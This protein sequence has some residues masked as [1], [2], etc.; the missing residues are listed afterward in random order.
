MYGHV[1]S[2][3]VLG[4]A[5]QRGHIAW[6]HAA[7]TSRCVAWCSVSSYWRVT[8]A[9][10]QAFRWARVMASWLSCLGTCQR[11]GMFGGSSTSHM[12]A[13]P[14]YYGTQGT[15]STCPLGLVVA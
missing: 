11:W 5:Q 14:G 15:R 6:V 7:C 4:Q 10:Q 2:I 8:Q 12:R 13:G 3:L 9:L 1:L